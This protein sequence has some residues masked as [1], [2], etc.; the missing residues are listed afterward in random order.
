[1]GSIESFACTKCGYDREVFSG[2]GFSGT[3]QGL[4]ACY[5]C[6]RLVLKKLRWSEGGESALRCPYCKRH[7]EPLSVGDACPTCDGEVQFGRG[8]II[9]EWD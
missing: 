1:L 3:G 2:I 8:G 5:H 4:C 6:H 7:V 9:G